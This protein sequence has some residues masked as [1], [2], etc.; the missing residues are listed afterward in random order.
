MTNKKTSAVRCVFAFSKRNYVF[1][2]LKRNPPQPPIGVLFHSCFPFFVTGLLFH[3]PFK[4]KIEF[5]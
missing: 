3:F 1:G 4:C 2:S 5:N